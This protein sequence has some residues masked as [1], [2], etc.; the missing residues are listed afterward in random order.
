MSITCQRKR[1]L[2]QKRQFSI[3]PETCIQSDPTFATDQTTTL[4]I[5][6]TC[7]PL[8]ASRVKHLLNHRNR[9]LSNQAI[10]LRPHAIARFRMSLFRRAWY[11]ATDD[12]RL[13]LFGF[14]RFR[15]A[16][17]NNRRF[18]EAEI[19]ELDHQIFQ[20]GLNLGI[21][22]GEADRLGLRQARKDQNLKPGSNLSVY[23]ASQ[24]R[25]L[26][27]EYGMQVSPFAMW[28]G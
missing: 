5:L 3:K 10:D 28:W 4:H 14:R 26:L 2:F 8:I 19:D 17:L 20:A 24:L 1:S 27:R 25:K 18:L 13:T 16:H 15:T 9:Q 21:K 6:Q 22:P 7:L 11:H 23:L 12:N